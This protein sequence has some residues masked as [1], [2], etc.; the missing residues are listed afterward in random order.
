MTEIEIT[1]NDIESEFC[2]RE[3]VRKGIILENDIQKGGVIE[4]SFTGELIPFEIVDDLFDKFIVKLKEAKFCYF[5]KSSPSICKCMNPQYAVHTNAIDYHAGPKLIVPQRTK[6]L[7]NPEGVDSPQEH[8]S[9]DSM[10]CTNPVDTSKDDVCEN[11]GKIKDEHS[12]TE[13]YCNYGTIDFKKFKPKE[14][15]GN[16][17]L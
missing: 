15:D 5:C 3:E 7:V 9:P 6:T 14:E 12:E 17:N 16:G 1:E 8:P 13:L 2:F 11:C 4:C 10:V